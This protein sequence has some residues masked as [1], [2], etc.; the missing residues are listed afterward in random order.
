M[1]L[2]SQW[3]SLNTL[4][5]LSD[6]EDI[7]KRTCTTR[8]PDS[9]RLIPFWTSFGELK[10]VYRS[11][12]TGDWADQ[13][14]QSM[15]IILL[16]GEITRSSPGHPGGSDFSLIGDCGWPRVPVTFLPG[17][18]RTVARLP[19]DW[20]FI[21]VRPVTWTG[22]SRFP[23]LKDNQ[24]DPKCYWLIPFIYPNH[25]TI[26][27]VYT[28]YTTTQKSHL[29]TTTTTTNPSGVWW[30]ICGQFRGAN[31]GSITVISD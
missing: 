13:T 24:V 7:V 22:H 19:L 28:C 14:L 6:I 11:K 29:S 26:Q 9:W 8:E 16:K 15:W 18:S 2:S 10:S 27:G 4:C 3:A 30:L 31:R 23:R 21:L 25:R 12:T 5:S 20:R 17:Q 1:F